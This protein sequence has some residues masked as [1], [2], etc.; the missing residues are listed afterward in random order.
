MAT[1]EENRWNEAASA[2]EDEGGRG[3][4]LSQ[5]DPDNDDMSPVYKAMKVENVFAKKRLDAYIRRL[6]QQR[7]QQQQQPPPQFSETA[8]AGLE[9]MAEDYLTKK[10]TIVLSEATYTAKND[11]MDMLDL[12]EKGASWPNKPI[13]Q[14]VDGFSWL[15][16][17]EDCTENR[18]AYMAYLNNL[19]QIPTHYAL[20]DA[21]PNRKLLTVELLRQMPES[22]KVSGTTD[23]AIAKSEHVHNTAVRNNIETLF[24][25]KTPKNMSKK[26]HTPQTIGE[27]FAASYLNP[28]HAVVSVLTDLNQKWTFFWFARGEDASKVALYKLCL[29]GGEATAGAKYLLDSLYDNAVGDTLPTTFANRQPF[30]AVM[31]SV[32]RNKRVKR[33]ID[34]DDSHSPDQDS[35]PSPSSGADQPPTSGTDAGSSSRSGGTAHQNNQGDAGGGGGAPMSMASALGLFAPPADRDVANELDLLDMVDE[36]EQYEIVRSFT[37]KHIVPFMTGQK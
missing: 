21:Q 29:D 28:D 10:K 35:K 8:K 5:F 3:I 34:R 6:R 24:E 36:S 16:G 14:H 27:H 33:E 4:P 11:L 23:V 20:A 25:L 32:A 13:L 18:T 37:S 1:D 19:L 9:L 26:D 12:P 30:Q 2:Y 31:D 17:D 7:L 15:K 22:R